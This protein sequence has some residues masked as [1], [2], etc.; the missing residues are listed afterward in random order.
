MHPSLKRRRSSRGYEPLTFTT[1][2]QP[3]RSRTRRRSFYDS[4]GA[5]RR[6]LGKI[7]S[8]NTNG[9]FSYCFERIKILASILLIT[10]AIYSYWFHGLLMLHDGGWPTNKNSNV[11]I[12]DALHSPTLP[13]KIPT[14]QYYNDNGRQPN[15]NT[16]SS[17]HFTE[18]QLLML[19]E[20]FGINTGRNTA[21]LDD[22]GS[23]VD[24]YSISRD[25]L[26]FDT[27]KNRNSTTRHPK[28]DFVSSVK[29]ILNE[30]A[31]LYG[32]ERV[33]RII[34]KNSI[35]QQFNSRQ[36]LE[37]TAQRM[38]RSR[39]SKRPF[40]MGFAGYSVTVGRGN[41]HNQSFPFVME[42]ILSN[43]M[44]QL[45]INLK[46]INGGIG[47]VPSLPYGLCL[48]NF[49]GEQ[50]PVDVVGWDFAMNEA[51]DVIG[52]L[53]CF[54]RHVHALNR[55][56]EDI[57]MLLIKDS[58]M[59]V[60]RTSMIQS[61]VDKGA[62][63]DPVIIHSDT[64][65]KPFL[66]MMSEETRPVGFQK[67]R[68]FG[69]PPRAPGRSKHHPAKREHDF[70][71]WLIAMHFLAALEIV[72]AVDLGLHHFQQQ[73]V[74][75]IPSAL[76]PPPISSTVDATMHSI[77]YGVFTKQGLKNSSWEMRPVQ[78]KTTFDP[79][80]AGPLKD[81]L[82]ST[83]I[84]DSL[85]IML[86]KSLM[87][88]NSGWV[89]DLGESERKAKQQL[90]RYGGLGFV[91]TKKAYRGVHAS[92]P[93]QFFLSLPSDSESLN[94]TTEEHHSVIVCEPNEQK[95][96]LSCDITKDITYTIG[97]VVVEDT[98]AITESGFTYLGRSICVLVP[99]P[100]MAV[101]SQVGTCNTDGFLLELVVTNPLIRKKT[102]ACSISHVIW[103]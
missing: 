99:V 63:R 59:A 23:L 80:L 4:G 52:G 89:L 21:S 62:F 103:V 8:A 75:E 70:I 12:S 24:A 73:P 91:D 55:Q 95:E 37:Y 16:S 22:N 2:R 101:K 3:T 72:A 38:Y 60:N 56:G 83:N 58:H 65:T 5:C 34:L 90:L 85:D 49:F 18:D 9:A 20:Q 67:W 39:E 46:V 87:F 10:S 40:V 69:A 61:Y 35:I 27:V 29:D 14:N 7:Q 92:G 11:S 81:I 68:E 19:L 44:K 26:S 76:L 15:S 88:Y 6:I 25:M 78:C 42:R 28:F 43:P 86:P 71:G 32:G 13:F 102:Q 50:H 84:Q 98:K 48:K 36:R 17:N 54:I 53:E 1:N 31:D 45:G 96:S 51:N 79:I 66:D 100:K 77:Y 97:G 93:I 74:F 94:K 57:P 64:V 82:V 30:F 33:A 41:Y 47:G